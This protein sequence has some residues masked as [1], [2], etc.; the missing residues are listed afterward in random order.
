M[1]RRFLRRS[2][3]SSCWILIAQAVE[4]VELALSLGAVLC[5]RIGPALGGVL[6]V[7]VLLVAAVPRAGAGA[8]AVGIRHLAV[9][10]A[11]IFERMQPVLA[12]KWITVGRLACGLSQASRHRIRQSPPVERIPLGDQRDVVALID[13]GQIQAASKGCLQRCGNRI[14]LGDRPHFARRVLLI[15]MA[16]RQ[17]GPDR[18]GERF[19]R[20][21]EAIKFDALWLEEIPEAGVRGET[22][23]ALAILLARSRFADVIRYQCCIADGRVGDVE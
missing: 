14:Q 21:D 16:Q 4:I 20:G 23:R 1:P 8:R 12:A 11:Q 9:Q 6:A 13:R 5:A 2:S 17:F 15:D 3:A 19:V 7:L 18:A 22:R 10:A